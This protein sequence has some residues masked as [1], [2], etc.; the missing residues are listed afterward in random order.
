M[1]HVYECIPPRIGFNF[2]ASAVET[3]A[4]A[5]TGI[6]KIHGCVLIH[7]RQEFV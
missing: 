1:M 7:V 2:V 6:E 3:I 4:V 5:E